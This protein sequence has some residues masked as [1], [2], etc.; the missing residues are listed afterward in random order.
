VLLAVALAAGALAA[1]LGSGGGPAPPDD[2]AAALVPADAL[3][4]LNLSLDRR[5]PSVRQALALVGRL[6]GLRALLSGAEARL[7]AIAGTA[8]DAGFA[9]A[10]APWLGDAAAF[11]LLNTPGSTAGSLLLLKDRAPAR[12][13]AF[14]ADLGARAAGRYRGLALAGL[15]DGGEAALVG[16]FLAFGQPASVRAAIDVAHGAPS[17][18]AS[19]GYRRAFAGQPAARVLDG[20]LP[21]AGARRLLLAQGGAIGAIGVLLDQP[22]LLGSAFSLVPAA[23]GLR[24]RIHSTFKPSAHA[25]ALPGGRASLAAEL[26]ADTIMM[27]DTRELVQIAPRVLSAG[28]TAGVGGA[29]GPLLARL[30]EALRAEGVDVSQL[31]TLLSG[32][33][34]VA[35]TD[36]GGHPALLVLARTPRPRFARAQLASLLVPL[37]QLFPAG[38]EGT[39][40]IGSFNQ[41]TIDGVSVQE[42]ALAPGLALDYAVWHGLIAL[43]TSATAIR[44]VIEGGRSLAQ[45]PG[46]RAAHAA[47]PPH[48]VSLLYLDPSQLLG[49]VERTRLTQGTSLRAL[50]ADLDGIHAIVLTSTGAE[51]NTTAELFLQIK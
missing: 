42:L 47:V 3:A 2:R 10:S 49:L 7:A 41:V 28:A 18:G 30:G 33:S 25:R 8:S 13:R 29:I 32:Q 51:T 50:R 23:G 26:P 39:V 5:R 36:N 14:L 43:S 11:A 40:P 1:A 48:A 22:R 38:S 21:G 12:A 27:L 6:P 44:A 35:V 4:Y 31:L 24:L 16:G 9:H 20:Y 46:Y 19:G 45:S 15:P 37:E 34:A 17:L